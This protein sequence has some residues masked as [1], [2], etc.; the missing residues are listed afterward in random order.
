MQRSQQLNQQIA[1]LEQQ[2][3]QQRRQL[4]AQTRAV[5]TA[6]R[7]RLSSPAAL[8][9]ATLGGALL[10]WWLY[11]PHNSTA[12]NSSASSTSS[13]RKHLTDF[14]VWLRSSLWLG[15]KAYLVRKII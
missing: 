3:P 4:G 14:V 10:G 7:Y 8:A 1:Q 6:V 15:C 5:S 12:D 9:V 13:T 2:L 11:H